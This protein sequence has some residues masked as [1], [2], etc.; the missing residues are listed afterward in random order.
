[1]IDINKLTPNDRYTITRY[2]ELSEFKD[3]KL[4]DFISDERTQWK[5]YLVEV[6][7]TMNVT[8]TL[9]KV[10]NEYDTNR[11]LTLEMK[12]NFMGGHHQVHQGQ[13]HNDNRR[14][15]EEAFD[16]IKMDIHKYNKIGHL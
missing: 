16:K 4:L 14:Y 9:G 10:K 15:A 11:Y 6:L 2:C 5:A 13:N 1:M 7:Y 8:S 12:P 3:F